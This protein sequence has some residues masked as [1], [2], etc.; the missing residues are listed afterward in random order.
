MVQFEEQLSVMLENAFETVMW[1]KQTLGVKWQ[2]PL[3]KFF[4]R[5]KLIETQGVVSMLPGT[6]PW[7]LER[8]P[9]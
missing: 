9:A 2:L 4:D 5:K 8:G 7:R 1:M 3:G 6:R